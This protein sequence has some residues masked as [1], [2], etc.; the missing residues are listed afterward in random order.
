M[1]EWLNFLNPIEWLKLFRNWLNRP[2]PEITFEYLLS[3]DNENEYCHLRRNVS[4]NNKMSWF[5]R[6]GVHNRG[7]QKI[8]EADVRVEKIEKEKNGTYKIICSSPFFLHWANDTTD[9]S[10]IIYPHTP[11]FLDVVF[12]VQD[13]NNFFVYH[14]S[15]HSVAGIPSLLP[16]GKYKFTIK[17]LGKNINPFQKVFLVNF[18]GNWEELRIKLEK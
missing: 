16:S 18:N 15:K 5:F 4:F 12:T 9:S 2:K 17:L 10:R 8:E 1:M 7:K 6:V 11:E 13:Y 3:Q 14:K